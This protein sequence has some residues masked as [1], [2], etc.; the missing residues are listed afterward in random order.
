MKVFYPEDRS[1]DNQGIRSYGK[2]M[3]WQYI[4]GFLT[5]VGSITGSI[6]VIKA[7]VKHEQ[8]ACDTRLEAFKEGLDRHD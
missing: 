6:W 1:Q 7:V 8:K 4:S 3:L 2:Q 5:A